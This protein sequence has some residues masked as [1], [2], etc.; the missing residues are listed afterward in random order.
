MMLARLPLLLLRVP[1]R[2]TAPLRRSGTA[3]NSATMASASASTSASTSASGAASP[4]PAP[5][6]AAVRP[7]LWRFNQGV[8]VTI[9]GFS[10]H[11]GDAVIR[12]VN[13][14]GTLRIKYADGCDKPYFSLTLSHLVSLAVWASLLAS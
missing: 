3:L 1:S 9:E 13:P 2:I 6:P 10:K 8:R 7:A 12:K 11:S 4:S 14:D 5:A